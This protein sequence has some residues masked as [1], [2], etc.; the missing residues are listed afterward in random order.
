MKYNNTYANLRREPSYGPY[1]WSTWI[2]HQS[3]VQLWLRQAAGGTI[4]VE[5]RPIRYDSWTLLSDDELNDRSLGDKKNFRHDDK[6]GVGGH[7][8]SVESSKDD[9]SLCG[10]ENLNDDE[11]LSD[12]ECLDERLSDGEYPNDNGCLSDGRCPNENEGWNDDDGNG[13]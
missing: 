3:D 13:G 4:E 12:D 8:C 7:P 5:I 6:I 2:H 11:S 1:N 10:G 9:R